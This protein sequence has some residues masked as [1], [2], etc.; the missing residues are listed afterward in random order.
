MLLIRSLV[1][2]ITSAAVG[3]ATEFSFFEPLQPP[4]PF[5]VMVHRGQSHQAPENTR[6]ALQRC[7]E[8]GLEWAEVDVRLTQDGQHIL[9]HDASLTDAAGK[10]WKINEHT[11]AE[12]RQVDVGARFAA[13]FAGEQLLSLAECFSLCKDRLN[14]YLD[15]KDVHPGHLAEEILESGL[16]RQVVVYASLEPARQLSRGTEGK[17]ATMTKWRP[18]CGGPEWAVTNG[19]AAVEIDAPDLPPAIVQAF[20]HAGIKVQ[21][22]V[23]DRW[24]QPAMWDRAI[25][26]GADW[27][28]TDLPEE[29]LAHA[30]WRRVPKRPVG[31]AL[32]RGANRYAPENT[33]PAFAKAVR[34]GADYVEFDVRTTR[35]GAYF[36]LHDSRLNRTTD[37][38]GPID[39]ITADSARKLSA[40]VKFG[41]AFAQTPLPTMDEFLGEFAGKIGF[42][43]DAK[44]I[45]PAALAAALEHYK[46]VDRTVVYQSP[47]YLAQL[48]AINPQIRGLA[49][50]GKPEA[51]AEL[52]AKFKPYGVDADWDILSQDLIARNHAAGVKVFSDSMGDHERVEDYLQAIDWGIDV[53]S[54]DHPLRVLRAIELWANRQAMKSAD[55]PLR[56]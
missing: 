49:P 4:R 22:K 54:T 40:G 34:L 14:L 48:K 43:F 8:D 50:L 18:G 26:A 33:L 51:F 21:A 45:P 7:I 20:R 17:V 52:A 36:L 24:D 12:L 30:L 11:L 29:L 23:L 28:Q 3:Q 32:H 27:L 2:L 9:S 1:V 38:T 6:P 47:Q 16:R 39:Q 44:V 5:Q 37:G 55:A 53:I 56:K 42:Y 31:L 46:V 25:D 15:C 19:L 35:D 13:R 10:V 41:Q